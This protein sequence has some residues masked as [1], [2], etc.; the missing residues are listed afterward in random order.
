[1]RKRTSFIL[2]FGMLATIVSVTVAQVGF[3]SSTRSPFNKASTSKHNTMTFFS[4]GG[5]KAEG[6]KA[7]ALPV[8]RKIKN[9]HQQLF[10]TPAPR[11]P[12]KKTF[13]KYPS[14]R[15]SRNKVHH[16]SHLTPPAATTSKIKHAEFL[17]KPTTPKSSGIRQVAGSN[18]ELRNP[19][20]SF[21]PETTRKPVTP[22]RQST[23][24]RPPVRYKN[25]IQKTSVEKKHDPFG[26]SHEKTFRHQA[27]PTSPPFKRKK[28]G[29]PVELTGLP[30]DLDHNSEKNTKLETVQISVG[31]EKKS[32]INVGQECEL[33]LIVKNESEVIARNLAVDA[34]FPTTVRL[35]K[36]IPIP[37]EERDHISWAIAALK[38]GETKRIK[39]TLI[40]MKPG[41]LAV[42]AFVRLTGTSA[43]L[44]A[45]NEPMLKLN[46]TGSHRV[47]VGES[48]AHTIVVSNP[49]TGVTSNIQ[50]EAILSKGLQHSK[51]ARVSLN[52]GSLN[53]GE[54]R[55]IHL[56]LTA[57]DGGLQQIDV[58]TR[59]GVSLKRSASSQVMVVA[60][61]LVL[62]VTGPKLRYKGR[63][64]IYKVTVTNSGKV[65]TNNVRVMHKIPEG[66]Q[67]IQADKS[68]K[69]N[70]Q[71][72]LV[73]WF[74]GQLP[75]GKSITLNVKLKATELGVFPHYVSVVSEE[76]AKATSH[77]QTKVDGT[78]SLVLEIV[79]LDDPV[80]VGSETAYEVRVKNDGSKAAN[81]VQITCE[82]P[83]DVQLIGAKGPTQSFAEKNQ[84]I[85]QKIPSLAPGKTALFRIHVKG[86]AEGNRRFRVRLQSKNIG[87]PLLFE[88]MTKFYG[89]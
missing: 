86:N 26:H 43:R 61:S 41:D 36:A 72:R 85:F 9:Y 77:V 40:P 27:K 75:V 25:K 12:Y 31:W 54:S 15:T 29:L 70:K 55:K 62:N 17:R 14:V 88:E 51:G 66:F 50:V 44:F 10:G 32:V 53:P 20:E 3:E 79:D 80:E 81:Q 64:A 2:T 39:V 74:I 76:G 49:G 7:A 60:P 6:K 30:V 1:M 46:V 69:L 38:P 4:R 18:K 22:K 82:L 5:Q 73:D 84:V 45:V 47:M 24:R 23:V 37:R 65:P 83:K 21:K 52:I 63:N 68:G 87:E 11:Q 13:S 8:K 67:F 34:Y 58:T 89:E 33:D 57:I 71:S 78:A 19:F 35:T 28:A 16:A 56:A 42:K 48:A 59:S